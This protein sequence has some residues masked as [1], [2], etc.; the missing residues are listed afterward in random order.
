MIV[1]LA[2]PGLMAEA[3]VEREEFAIVGVAAPDPVA[4]GASAWGTSAGRLGQR[5]D[6]QNQG[7]YDYDCGSIHDAAPIPSK[8]LYGCKPGVKAWKQKV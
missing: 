2:S 4:A 3:G 1:I 8:R 5:C 7:C 6:G